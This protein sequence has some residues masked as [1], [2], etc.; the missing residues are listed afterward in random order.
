VTTGCGPG[1]GS[2]AAW[3]DASAGA[4]G[5]MLLAALIDAGAD[6][7]TVS[8]AIGR[9]SAATGERLAVDLTTVRRHGLR[10]T[11]AAVQA[12][13]SQTHRGLADVLA[14]IGEADLAASAAEF[15]AR[16]FGLLA[17]AEARV[18]GVTAERVAF[19]E[20]GALDSLADVIGTAVALDS[21]GL[22]AAD[23]AVTVSSVGVGSGSVTTAHGSLPVPVPAVVV[24]LSDAGAPVSAGPLPGEGE[25]CT[26]TGAALLAALAADWGPMPPMIV[27][28][29]GSGAGARDPASH[30]NII[31]V[32]VGAPAGHAPAWQSTALRLVEST[33]DD[34]DPRLWPD[35]LDALQT[36]GAIDCWLT[37]VLMRTGRPG[38]VVTALTQ[39]DT[40]DSVV[41]TLLRVTTTLGVRV[42]EVNRLAVPRDQIE[43]QVGGQ[44]VRVKRGWLD[45]A[46]VTVQPE[47]ADARAA[48]DLLGIPV[49]DVID[50][51]R[52]AARGA[53]GPPKHAEA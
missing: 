4:A 18:H 14:L 19:H 11:R 5:D 20:V 29:A 13:P 48:A 32:L 34:L 28:S 50:A 35:A 39:A 3:I 7:A 33:I 42:T 16:V 9:L 24:L 49:A 21:L 8:S 37:P 23:A 43:V 52:T 27:R 30:A 1:Q 44:P 53:P 40:V 26:P 17:D 6:R 10:A 22:L 15:A 45:G 38:Q 12:G 47:F 31:R 51:A 25:L 41:R 36:A 46:A 2:A